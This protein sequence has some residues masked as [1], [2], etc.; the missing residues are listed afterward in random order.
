VLEQAAQRGCGCFV[1]GSVQGH[2]GWDPGQP[3]L[4][5]DLEVVAGRVELDD[6]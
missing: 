2:V 1:L 4:I 5:P 6:P 3:D